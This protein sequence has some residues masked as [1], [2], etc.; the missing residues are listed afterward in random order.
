MV[1][2]EGVL[3]GWKLSSVLSVKIWVKIEAWFMIFV[4]VQVV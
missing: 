2:V 4:I 3:I 1:Y